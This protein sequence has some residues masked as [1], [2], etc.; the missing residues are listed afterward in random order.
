[1]VDYIRLSVE[2]FLASMQLFQ[3]IWLVSERIEIRNHTLIIRRVKDD[4]KVV[5]EAV[6]MREIN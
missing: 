6:I 3:I 2:I 4:V 5:K 1:M